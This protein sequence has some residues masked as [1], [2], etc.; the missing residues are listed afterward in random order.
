MSDDKET[1]FPNREKEEA[2]AAAFMDQRKVETHLIADMLRI[3]S[4]TT[5]LKEFKQDTK[6]QL[7]KLENWIIA[8]VVI[9]GM[10][11][12]GTLMTVVMK[13]TGLG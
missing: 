3:E 10:S 5:E 7:K 11:L 13:L 2:I 4:L 12:I 6:D 8:I 1:L 9:T